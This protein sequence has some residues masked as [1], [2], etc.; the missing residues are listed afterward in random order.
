MDLSNHD[1]IAK[2]Y[3]PKERFIKKIL[4]NISLK[5]NNILVSFIDVANLTLFNNL[6]LT[7][8][9]TDQH[10]E[11][12]S[13]PEKKILKLPNSIHGMYFIPE[14]F[15]NKEITLDFNLF[16]NRANV[17]RQ[18][19]FYKII[20]LEWLQRGAVSYIGS[21]SRTNN[22]DLDSVQLLDHLHQ[23]FFHPNYSEIYS[24]ARKLVPYQNFKD[25]GDLRNVMMQTKLSVVIETYHER[26]D[27]ISFSEKIFR[28]LQ[29]P[30]PWVLSGATGSV[31]Q[32]RQLGFDVFDDYIDHSYD[33]YCTKENITA[34]DQ[35]ILNQIE[36]IKHLK[37]TKSII[38]D[39]N[40]K[41][42]K[43]MEILSSWNQT[44]EID[45][46]KF[47]TSNFHKISNNESLP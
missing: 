32:L 28:A 22:P 6:S 19:W 46:E 9:V 44:W 11:Q 23:E 12:S 14:P 29:V 3:I 27:A 15:L 47:I 1:I 16:I 37:V 20:E 4:K 40:K 8:V 13:Y 38:D 34:R 30:R 36:N 18:F 5:E 41:Y 35:A 21:S 7:T 39:W 2:Y 25:L 26:T 17:N 33:V 45:L 24:T 31:A 10:I 42:L 43:N